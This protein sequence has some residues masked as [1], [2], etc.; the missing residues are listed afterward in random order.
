M[1]G[2][3]V[4]SHGKHGSY[5]EGRQGST[6]VELWIFVTA[7]LSFVFGTR[8]VLPR[9]IYEIREIDKVWKGGKVKRELIL[10]AL[11]PLI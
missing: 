11:Y 4:L 5:T 7:G 10:L 9:N 6:S 2:D 8:R 3:F 1:L